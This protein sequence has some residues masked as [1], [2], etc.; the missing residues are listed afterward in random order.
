MIAG[1]R[2]VEKISNDFVSNFLIQFFNRALVIFC[3]RIVVDAGENDI[4]VLSGI[5][6]EIFPCFNLLKGDFGR[7]F[8][9]KLHEN[10]G[11]FSG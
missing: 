2:V 10:K 6:F 7:F 11:T 3:F 9:Y 1:L 8:I 4:P 5:P